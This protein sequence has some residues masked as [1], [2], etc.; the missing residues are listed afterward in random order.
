M[1]DDSTGSTNSRQAESARP[2]GAVGEPGVAVAGAGL[3]VAG[4][5]VVAF[6]LG[7]GAGR[8]VA[9]GITAPTAGVAALFTGSAGHNTTT[10]A[11]QTAASPCPN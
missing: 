5:V 9:A 2:P 4:G 11:V 8:V 10:A 3:A 7:L 1:A 6:G